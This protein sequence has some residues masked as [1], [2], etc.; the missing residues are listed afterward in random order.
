ML[1]VLCLGALVTLHLRLMHL[2]WL[3]GVLDP[4]GN[5][6]VV[7]VEHLLLECLEYFAEFVFDGHLPSPPLYFYK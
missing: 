5:F 2:L 4:K 7:V 3:L 6:S 1:E